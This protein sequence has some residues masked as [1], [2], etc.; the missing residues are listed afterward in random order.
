MM[1]NSGLQGGGRHE[2]AA[3]KKCL[4]Y[5]SPS[6]LS[7]SVRLNADQHSPESVKYPVIG[8]KTTDPHRASQE[9]TEKARAI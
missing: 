9:Q 6:D 7:S 5:F 4:N 1:V 2:I 3:L 8:L